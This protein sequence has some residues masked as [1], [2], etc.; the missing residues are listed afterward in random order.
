MQRYINGFTVVSAIFSKTIPYRK[1]FSLN[2]TKICS[3]VI[4]TIVK[5]FVNLNWNFKELLS[6]SDKETEI[7]TNF[8]VDGIT[9]PESR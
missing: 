2:D 4:I 6:I 3:L 7:M 1:N 5:E 9:L 8:L